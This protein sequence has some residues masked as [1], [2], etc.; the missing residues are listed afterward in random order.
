M[1]LTFAGPAMGPDDEDD[2]SPTE[3]FERPSMTDL[4]AMTSEVRVKCAMRVEHMA[5]KRRAGRS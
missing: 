2:D 1:K 5:Q 3:K 4:V